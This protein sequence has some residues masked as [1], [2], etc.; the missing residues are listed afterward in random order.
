MKSRREATPASFDLLIA[1]PE[2]DRAIWRRVRSS[3]PSPIAEKLRWVGA[4]RMERTLQAHQR[5]CGRGQ[6]TI[7]PA[8]ALVRRMR[9]RTS[10]IF[11]PERRPN[12]LGGGLC[13]PW[14]TSIRSRD[15]RDDVEDATNGLAKCAPD[16]KHLV[17]GGE[18]SRDI[19]LV[20][21]STH[22]LTRGANSQCTC[23]DSVAHNRGARPIF[24]IGRRS[25]SAITVGPSFQLRL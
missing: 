11:V 14:Q 7:N 13:H 25:T 24:R 5:S 9:P 16:F 2:S 4:E 20:A 1:P 3:I 15:I 10:R 19:G 6:P 18:R 8:L 22:E 21:R 23:L 12:Q 17:D